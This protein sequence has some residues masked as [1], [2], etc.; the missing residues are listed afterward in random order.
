MTTGKRKKLWKRKKK[1][2]YTT[3]TEPVDHNAALVTF[4][5]AARELACCKMTINNLVKRGKLD[6][7]KILDCTR[8]TRQSLNALIENAPRA[9]IQDRGGHVPGRPRKA[10]TALRDSA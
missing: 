3:H 2:V 8:V 7:I 1:R 10:S 9:L 5:Q 4:A 6:A